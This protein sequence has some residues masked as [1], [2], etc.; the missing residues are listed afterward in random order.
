MKIDN[1]DEFDAESE[2]VETLNELALELWEH[3]Y[4]H[5]KEPAPKAG[6]KFHS[7]PISTHQWAWEA[8]CKASRK[9]EFHADPD[10]AVDALNDYLNAQPD[11]EPCADHWGSHL[12]DAA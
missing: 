5:T 4:G 3:R 10:A 2:A 6:T 9:L 11:P 12:D 7:S 8:A 1:E